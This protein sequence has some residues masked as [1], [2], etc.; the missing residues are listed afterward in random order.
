MIDLPEN[1]ERQGPGSEKDTPKALGFLEFSAG[2]KLNSRYWLRFR[3]SNH[4]FGWK[5]NRTNNSSWLVPGVFEWTQ[6]EIYKSGLTDKIV[7]LEKSMDDLP[8]KKMNL[9]FYGQKV[10]FI[11]FVLKTGWNN[12]KTIWKPVAIGLWV[13]LPGQPNHDPGK[14]K[15]FGKRNILK[16]MLLPLK[17]WNRKAMV[18]HLQDNLF[19]PKQLDW[20]QL[21]TNGGM[22]W[23]LS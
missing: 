11:T 10:R 16:L 9:T 8:S 18:I 4:Y 23:G 14:L 15:N 2:R 6:W 1:P 7:T 20:E 12:G 17:S 22:I 21:Q 5:F 19:Q 3:W 13:R